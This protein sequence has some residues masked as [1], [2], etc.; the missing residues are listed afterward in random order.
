[1]KDNKPLVKCPYCGK[2]DFVIFNPD[3]TKYVFIGGMKFKQITY[4]CNNPIDYHLHSEPKTF[5]QLD[6]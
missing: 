2:S 5:K 3:D 1:M 6:L 4:M